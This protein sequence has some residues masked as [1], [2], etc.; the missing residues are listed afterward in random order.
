MRRRLVCAMLLWCCATAALAQGAAGVMPEPAN[1]ALPSLILIGDSTVRNGRDDGQGKGAQG[2]WGWGNP[3][4][5]YFDA[6][7]TN[8]VNRAIGG[9]SSRTYLSGGH[10][11]R[12]LALVKAGDV[13]LMQF[14]HNDSGAVNDSSRARGTLKGVG[15][16]REE[17][18]NL[19]TGQRETVHSYGW[20]LR[21]YIADI[22]AR[23]ATAVICSPV[24]RKAW[25]ANGSVVRNRDSYAGWA[26]QVAQQQ[27]VGFIDLNEQVAR[28]Y[29]TLG[30]DAVMR[31]FPQVTPDEHTHTNL[32]GAEL[33]ARTVVAGLKTLRLP[34]LAFSAAGEAIPALEDERP[35]ADAASVAAEMP[36]DTALPTL[37]LVGD[38]TVKSGGA[39][40][41][42]GW[43][44]R[45]APFFDAQK[46]NVVNHAIGGRSSRTF[47]TE[48]RWGRV[49]EQIRPGDVVAI[50]FGHNDGGRIGDPA[51]KGRA[52]GKGIGAETVEDVRPDGTLEQVHTFGWYMAKY[53][54]DARARGA[55]VILLSPV[56]HR[57]AW[58]QGRDF[59]SV[60]EWDRQVAQ[61][62]GAQFADLTMVISD[63]YRKLGARTV[64]TYFSD[65]RTHTNE[66]GA[67]FN[68]RSV[69]SA[70]KGLQGNP[71]GIYL[72]PDG[73]KI[74][75]AASR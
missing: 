18:D 52:S 54:A 5:A 21:H 71:L 51:M 41:A 31:L 47:Y 3:L 13:V 6:S 67:V 30:R 61:A 74:P 26:R 48:G 65:A 72:S 25:D 8:V 64:D 57:D 40:G 68:A 29:D 53:V 62:G 39:H 45:I 15:E 28:Q 36:R 4:A 63:G 22:Q 33:N 46:I 66:A 75:V 19:L 32:A 42:I 23:G 14:G 27:Q 16:E 35:L 43:G 34:L 49:L 60:A 20:Y 9:L 59:A 10:W 58:Q 73:E 56:P 12:T 38:S 1:P 70:F 37:F 24:P 69:V 7:K 44:E 55:Q 11:Q 50:Q 2:Q 17:I